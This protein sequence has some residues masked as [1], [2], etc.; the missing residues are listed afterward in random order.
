VLFK[1]NYVHFEYSLTVLGLLF[2][3][4]GFKQLQTHMG[5]PT[6]LIFAMR[7]KIFK[8]AVSKFEYSLTI[9]IGLLGS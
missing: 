2:K 8:F 4:V 9:T 6:L 5:R 1:M 3:T 7:T